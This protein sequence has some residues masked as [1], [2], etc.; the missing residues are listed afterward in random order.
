MSSKT[1]GE[2]IFDYISFHNSKINKQKFESYL[3]ILYDSV[4]S[5]CGFSKEVFL[6]LFPNIPY[7]IREKFY[8]LLLKRRNGNIKEFTKKI[9]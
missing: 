5:K 2:I 8:E 1:N 6:L 7:L 3:N 9:L 4:N